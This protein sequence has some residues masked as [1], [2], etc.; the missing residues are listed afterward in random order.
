LLIHDH[1]PSLPLGSADHGWA[2]LG[3]ASHGFVRQ[4][5]HQFL[6]RIKKEPLDVCEKKERKVQ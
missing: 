4:E 6:P 1:Q 2:W 5:N 3:L